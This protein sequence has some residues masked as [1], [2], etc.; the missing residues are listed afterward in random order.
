MQFNSYSGQKKQLVQ[1]S[2]FQVMKTY[3]P[4]SNGTEAIDWLGQNCETCKT[5]RGCIGQ[6]NIEMGFITGEIS[7][8]AWLFIGF[9]DSNKYPHPCNWKDKREVKKHPKIKP[10][11]T[12]NYFLFNLET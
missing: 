12:D 11:Q 3:I 1:I 6:R 5:S 4:F 10:P 7:Q 8:K 9:G 2:Q